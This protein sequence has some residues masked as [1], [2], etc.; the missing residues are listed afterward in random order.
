MDLS[1]S[2]SQSTERSNDWSQVVF[3]LLYAVP[4]RNGVYK[5]PSFHGKGCRL[6]NMG[7]MFG[8]DF[9]SDQEMNR[10]ALTAAELAISTLQDGDLLFG[11]R[12]VVEAGAGK[13][14]LVVSPT[15]PLAFESS[16]IRVRLKADIA[17]PFFFYYFFNSPEGRQSIRNIVSGTNVKGIRGS[18]LR[19]ILVPLPSPPEQR[20]IAAALSDVDALI[21][22]I[23]RLIAKKHELKQAAMQ[24]LLTGEVR[25]P[26]FSGTWERRRLGGFTPSYSQPEW[27]PPPAEP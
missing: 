10:V 22:S 20:A 23:D 18:E 13:C 24:Q 9:I 2:R 19:C 14:S 26:G 27:C 11:R 25:L 8:Y 5:A 21:D 12:S 4:S 17:I 1:P 3:G 6:V 16:I 7:E 15:S